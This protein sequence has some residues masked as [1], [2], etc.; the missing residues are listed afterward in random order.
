M[1]K[2]LFIA[3]L[4]PATFFANAQNVGIGITTPQFPLSF[5]GNLG[6]KISLWTD[7]TPTHYGFGIQGGLLQMFSKTSLDAIGF[8]Y[9]SSSAFTEL[10]R[11]KGNGNVG[12]GNI[13][14]IF[15]LDLNGRMRIRSGGNNSVSAGLWVNNNNNDLA[16]FIGMEDDTHVGFFGTG[17]G[18]KLGMNTQTG[19][20]KVN[21]SEGNSGQVLQ[22][23]GSGGGPTWVSPTS[24]LYNNTYS[25]GASSNLATSGTGAFFDLPGLNQNITLTQTSKLL[26]SIHV[27]G[28]NNGCFGCGEAVM[29]FRLLIDNN[30][31]YFQ[32]KATN[33]PNGKSFD[34]DSG[35]RMITLG[36][37]VHNFKMVVSHNTGG[38]VQ[39]YQDGQPYGT[40]MVIM[41]IAQ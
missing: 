3:W 9:G 31:S 35:F 11:I 6:D 26:V 28:Y 1:K 19:A 27:A 30:P 17:T 12:I 33:T 40:R 20:I 37:G 39:V 5:N 10:M 32:Y 38:D 18:W 34:E 29:E 7:G 25:F 21:G 4:L 16:A 23:N 24:Q 22:S 8:G 2:I 36:A 14:P 13:N 15:Q 41:V